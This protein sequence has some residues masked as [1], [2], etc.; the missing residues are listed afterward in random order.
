MKA[1]RASPMARLCHPQLAQLHLDPLLRSELKSYPQKTRG[2]GNFN[3]FLAQLST[4]TSAA[5]R[6]LKVNLSVINDSGS[7]KD[8][9]P[10]ASQA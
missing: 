2:I 1:A 3:F 4:A 9:S 7:N 6:A 8:K 10:A 5:G